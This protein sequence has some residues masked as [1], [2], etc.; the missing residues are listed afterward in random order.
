[1]LKN[2]LVSL[3]ASGVEILVYELIIIFQWIFYF[4]SL[5]LAGEFY[6]EYFVSNVI[7]VIGA[8]I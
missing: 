2:N 4:L 5:F 8:L 7:P 1:M 6:L 3:Y